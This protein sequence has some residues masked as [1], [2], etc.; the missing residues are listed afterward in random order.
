MAIAA[1][2]RRLYGE[3]VAVHYHDVDDPATPA[4][5]LVVAGFAD[6]LA[7]AQEAER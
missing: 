1:R 7:R 2:L 3:P 4:M 6:R 5:V